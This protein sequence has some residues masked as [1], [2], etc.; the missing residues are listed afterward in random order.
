MTDIISHSK[1]RYIRAQPYFDYRVPFSGRIYRISIS[2]SVG[3]KGIT[4]YGY[5]NLKHKDGQKIAN[6]Y[7]SNVTQYEWVAPSGSEII[8]PEL[9]TINNKSPMT[10]N[11]TLEF[12]T[13]EIVKPFDQRLWDLLEGRFL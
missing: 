10:I 13:Q 3:Y 6:I 4:N 8:I 7:I 12:L 5:V 1:K 9:L 11:V 2:T